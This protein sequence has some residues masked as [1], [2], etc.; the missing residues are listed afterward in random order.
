MFGASDRAAAD[1]HRA[2]RR[3][4]LVLA[5]LIAAPAATVAAVGEGLVMTAQQV[6]IGVALGFCLQLVFDAVTLGGQ[7]IANSMG[8]SFA[9][10]LDPLRGGSAAPR[11]SGSSTRCS[12]R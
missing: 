9:F 1:P 2:G 8:L 10:N 7:L 6:V 4:R 3:H 11:P 5:P 12:S